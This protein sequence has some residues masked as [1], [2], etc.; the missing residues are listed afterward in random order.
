MAVD[1]LSVTMDPALG[2]A[3]R[4][5]A[6]GAGMSVSAWIAEAV[7]EKVR[8]RLLGEVLDTWEAEDG[9]LTEQELSAARA[10]VAG[11]RA[12]SSRGAA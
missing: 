6:A 4:A 9:A 2:V 7:A 5:A 1:R 11:V 8:H 3:A 12:P 10:V